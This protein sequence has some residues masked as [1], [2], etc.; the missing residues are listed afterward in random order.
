MPLRSEPVYIMR[1]DDTYRSGP[2]I[3]PYYYKMELDTA[4][5]S[6]TSCVGASIEVPSYPSESTYFSS[7]T[8]VVNMGACS[9]GGRRGEKG[10]K[11][12]KGDPGT[13][14]YTELTDKPLINNVVLEGNKTFEDLGA[15]SITDSEIDDIIGSTD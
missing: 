5:G 12:D 6:C 9:A 4:N 7:C 2:G 8:H 15:Y 13:T 1:P 3:V 14:T 11:G 10:E